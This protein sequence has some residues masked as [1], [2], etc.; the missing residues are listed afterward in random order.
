MQRVDDLLVGGGAVI[1]F[2][3]A[4]VIVRLER[5]ERPSKRD[6]EWDALSTASERMSQKYGEPVKAREH[7]TRGTVTGGF[8]ACG[9][10]FPVYERSRFN[11]QWRA[12]RPIG[13]V[14]SEVGAMLRSGAA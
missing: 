3:L 4:Y 7:R 9:R 12:L 1:V 11:R 13:E 6:L 2:V 5:S 14:A 8:E 10:F